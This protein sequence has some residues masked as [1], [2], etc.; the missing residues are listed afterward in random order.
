MREHNAAARRQP[1]YRG[2]IV[3]TDE[4]G[5]EHHT[6]QGAGSFDGAGLTRAYQHKI[7]GSQAALIVF[8]LITGKPLIV[9]HD[10][11]S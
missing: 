10:Q 5:I 2:D 8:S 3:W 7:K 11:V 6:A 9:L 4:D 1:T